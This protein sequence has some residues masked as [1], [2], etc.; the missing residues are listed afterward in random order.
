MPLLIFARLL[1]SIASLAVLYGAGYLLWSWYDGDVYI[2]ATDTL[3]RTREDWRLVL[4]V[5]LIAFSFLGRFVIVPL[6]GRPDT[7]ETRLDL[8]RAAGDIL[9]T[10]T[11]AS[12]YVEQ[13][14]DRSKPTILFTHGWGLDSTI[15]QY[16]KRDLSSDFHLVFWDLPGLGKSKAGA[17]HRFDPTRFSLE[18]D[19]VMEFIGS[20]GVV[21]VGHS[22]GGMTIQT[23][24]R[25]APD[26]VRS[27]VAGIVLLNTTFTNPIDTV[28]GA[29]VFKALRWPLIEPMLFLTSMLQPLAWL[30]AWRAYL[31]G[32]A[33][34]ANRVQFGR[35]VTR[36]Q[37]NAVTL[38]GTR[39]PQ[40]VLAQ[41]N[42]G[43]FRWDASEAMKGYD[44][45]VLIIGGRVDLA[46]KIEASRTI[47][48]DAPRARLIEVDDV[49]HNGFLENALAYNKAII[50][51]VKGLPKRDP[52]EER[53]DKIHV[54]PVAELAVR[55]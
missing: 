1:S 28:F 21:L 7:A 52:S 44:G 25:D 48:S 32:S 33:H 16:A 20:R 34:I 54:I 55:K 36:S 47:A 27:R 15:W 23:L 30:D 31:S 38:L 5:A 41:G 14:G 51:F 46:T 37:L 26:R 4:G 2:T 11:G 35:K 13:H 42:L 50:D 12:L 39:N 19:A 45:P 8:Q 29:I 40:G 49:N 9:D 17:D 18:L 43:M 6:L 22:V 10:P 24:V 53:H 3:E